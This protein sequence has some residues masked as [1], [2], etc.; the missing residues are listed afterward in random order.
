MI[1]EIQVRKLLLLSQLS[2]SMFVIFNRFFFSMKED[3]HLAIEYQFFFN[4]QNANMCIVQL[5]YL[6]FWCFKLDDKQRNEIG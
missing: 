3:K 6:H 4:S 1:Y 5:E 2:Y